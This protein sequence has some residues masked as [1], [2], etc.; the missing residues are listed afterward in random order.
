MSAEPLGLY[1]RIPLLRV[2]L[3]GRCLAS[4]DLADDTVLATLARVHFVRGDLTAAVAA[5]EAALALMDP[6]LPRQVS[7]LET[8]RQALA[9][10]AGRQ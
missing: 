3:V 6:P 4:P 5:Q 1:V 10:Q 8:Y 2:A 9:A 7:V